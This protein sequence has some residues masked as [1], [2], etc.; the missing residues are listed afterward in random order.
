M[1]DSENIDRD[2]TKLHINCV[3]S[4]KLSIVTLKCRV[5]QVCQE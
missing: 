5:L 4:V 2:S 1:N 3:G